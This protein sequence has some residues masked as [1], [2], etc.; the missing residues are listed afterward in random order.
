MLRLAAS[1]PVLAYILS[2]VVGDDL[3]TIALRPTVAPIGTRAEALLEARDL[4]P[5]LP[6]RVRFHLGRDE[7]SPRPPKPRHGTT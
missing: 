1:T 6:E 7:P 5:L 2:D 3:G 4:W